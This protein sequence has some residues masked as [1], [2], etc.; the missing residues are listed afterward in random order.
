MKIIVLS[1]TPYKEKDTILSAISENGVVSFKVRGGQTSN[2][3]FTW[4]HN[5]LTI[6]DVEFVDNPRY[7]NKI[8]K[9]AKLIYSPLNNGQD[10]SNLLA[11]K[12]LEETTNKMFS[13][14][15]KH[16]MFSDI[17][18][19]FTAN[20]G[21]KDLYLSELIFLIRASRIAGAGLEFNK[22]VK[23]GSKRDI[24]AFS[25]EEGG[26]VCRECLDE[27][28]IIDLN[29]K[30]MKVLRYC[31]NNSYQNLIEDKVNENIS[32]LDKKTI[33]EK[34]GS[35]IDNIVG[36]HLNSLSEILKN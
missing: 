27:S 6:A 28:V 17:E 26:F 30:Q 1:T 20:K 35:F 25:F 4:L 22:C 31:A 9:G 3:P 23:C 29:A 8:V 16:L 18:S 11:I 24:V 21:N 5:P 12:L 32:E 36:V 13:D 19:F 33:L 34:F 14:E 2:G 7:T 10:L 15:D